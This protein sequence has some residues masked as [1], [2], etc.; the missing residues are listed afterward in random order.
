VAVLD[1]GDRARVEVGQVLGEVRDRRGAVV[2]EVRAPVAGV[3]LYYV[4]TLAI[5][6]GDPLVGI[7]A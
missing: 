1:R 4:S 3:V 6:R 5:D 2:Q 7:G